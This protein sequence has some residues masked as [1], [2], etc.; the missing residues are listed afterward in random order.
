MRLEVRRLVSHVSVS[1]SMALVK[2]VS[3][4]REHGVPD[5]LDHRLVVALVQAL[6]EEFRLE[7]C[8]LFRH[9]LS[10]DTADVVSATQRVATQNLGKLH[11]LFLVHDNAVR[12]AK[13]L[14]QVRM[15]AVNLFLAVLTGNEV[16]NLVNRPRS[17]QGVHSD[18]VKDSSRLQLAQV[19]LHTR[20]FELE[21]RR[22][23]AL[24]QKFE[25]R[26]VINRNLVHH[27][28]D[29]A[30]L[31]DHL[32]RILNDGQVDK[33]KEVHLQKS[34]VF[35]VVL[36]VHHHRR[37]FR[38]GTVKWSK[39]VNRS[40]RNHHAASMHA[41]LARQI[42]KSLCDIPK[43]LVACAAANHRLQRFRAV[44]IF[45]VVAL[46]VLTRPGLL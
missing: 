30:V 20:R 41:R 21:H 6:L 29:V 32:H 35:G 39:V 13:H 46:L 14:F 4:E 18:K 11:H 40:R 34:D 8:H 28:L 44:T 23:K 24:A 26:L 31:F 43:V 33:P 10:H 22:R 25:R 36:I 1:C 7:L 12:F 17:V 42:F 9:L 5:L 38:S 37:I 27:K 2:C 45:K 19:L 15:V 16:R 3:A